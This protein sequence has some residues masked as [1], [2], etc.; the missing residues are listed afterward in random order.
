[1][2]RSRRH[3]PIVGNTT[4]KSDKKSKKRA[5]GRMRRRTREILC[6]ILRR[7][8]KKPLVFEDNRKFGDDW[9]TTKDGK[10]YV[11]TEDDYVRDHNWGSEGEMR[12]F[13]RGM[14]CK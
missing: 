14:M 11:G 6:H 1:M 9:D 12:D 8:T 3:T 13:Y 2:S 7:D 4:S 10:H 5:H